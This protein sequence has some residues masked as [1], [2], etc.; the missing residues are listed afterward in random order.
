MKQL[1]LPAAVQRT[2]LAGLSGGEKARLRIAEMLLSSANLLILDEVTNHLDLAAR[3]YLKEVPSAATGQSGCEIEVCSLTLPRVWTRAVSTSQSSIGG[4]A[5]RDRWA[6]PQALRYFD[7][8]V[9]L[10]THDRFFAAALAT[11]TL[12]RGAGR[13]GRLQLV[14]DGCSLSTARNEKRGP[15]LRGL[16]TILRKLRMT[17]SVRRR[18]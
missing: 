5:V 15:S 6:S 11:R 18:S 1:G 16:V 14:P 9:L 13:V 12:P 2:P 7:G 8:S 4:P 17:C 10:A 3:G